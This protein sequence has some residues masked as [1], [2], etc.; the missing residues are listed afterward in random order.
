V[1]RASLDAYI[2][3]HGDGGD[4]VMELMPKAEDPYDEDAMDEYE[5]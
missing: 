5:K 1:K 2:P 4:D 3:Y